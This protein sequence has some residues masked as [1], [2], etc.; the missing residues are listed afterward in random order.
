M[1]GVA[2][3]SCA[4][5]K[6]ETAIIS[7]S[8]GIRLGLYNQV[9]ERQLSWQSAG[10]DLL[11]GLHCGNRMAVHHCDANVREEEAQRSEVWRC[12]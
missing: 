3:A 4:L 6:F 8:P 11:S 5:V 10:L 9:T 12:L 1:W 2:F 7:L